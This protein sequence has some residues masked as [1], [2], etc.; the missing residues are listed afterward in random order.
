LDNFFF[1]LLVIFFIVAPILEKIL[2]GQ[3]PMPPPQQRRPPAQRHTLPE[4]RPA[5]GESQGRTVA[6][7]EGQRDATDLLPA[8]LWEILTGKRPDRS[9]QSESAQTPAPTA[10]RSV[11]TAPPPA[12]RAPPGQA[13]QGRSQTVSRP[14]SVGAPPLDEAAAAAELNRRREQEEARR[15]RYDYSTGKAVSLE[16]EIAPEAVRHNA[17]HEKLARL[18]EPAA[19]PKRQVAFDLHLNDVAALQ[20]AIVLQEVFGRPKGLDD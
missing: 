13:R 12:R 20:H 7:P 18:P 10:G 19:G 5:T 6:A 16:V 11:S 17:F 4:G 1:V 3:R 15:R 9:R 2:K 14:G 8:E